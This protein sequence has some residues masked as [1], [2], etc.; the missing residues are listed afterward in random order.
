MLSGYL[1][2]YLFP[3]MRRRLDDKI[4][5]TMP[6]ITEPREVSRIGRR[7]CC[8]IIMPSLELILLRNHCDLYM[9]GLQVEGLE[10]LDR[11][12]QEGRG[13]IL[14]GIHQGANAA[15][16]AVMSLLG[17]VYTP[18][19]LYPEE[20]PVAGYY[21]AML[22]YGHALGCDEEEPV[23]WTGHDTFRRVKEHLRRGKRVGIDIDVP[24]RRVTD[25]FGR[26]A[27][28]A[29]GIARFALDTGAA[30]I[31]FQ[32]LQG[33]KALEHR[34]IIHPPVECI[35]SGDREKDIEVI[36]DKVVSV[37]EAM[38]REAPGQ[39]MSWFG[40]RGFWVQADNKQS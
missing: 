37:A 10:Y 23:F 26:S 8:T 6:E 14:A 36:M 32:L 34:L 1:A 17:K 25:F 38:I 9:R 33:S 11:A 28:L 13:V 3:P 29:D 40:V 24:G 30:I 4:A 21:G 18:I 5:E 27:A 12:D 39:W 19:F 15:R 2:Y 31:P 20:S 22:R 16:I 35:L 7:A